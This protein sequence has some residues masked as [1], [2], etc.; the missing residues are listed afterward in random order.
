MSQTHS[1]PGA[2]PSEHVH[3]CDLQVGDRAEIVGFH[4]SDPAYASKIVAMGLTRG[5]QLEILHVAPLGD[6][7]EVRVLGFRLALRKREASVLKLKKV[8]PSGALC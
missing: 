1:E 5:V 8:I 2:K 4:G 6:P 3:L 7:V